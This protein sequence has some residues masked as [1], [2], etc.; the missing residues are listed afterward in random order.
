MQKLLYPFLPEGMRNP[1]TFNRM[2]NNPDYRAHIEQVLDKQVH[3]DWM[4]LCFC[5]LLDIDVHSA[6]FLLPG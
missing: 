1:E 3:P 5:L 2:M 4:H 6:D